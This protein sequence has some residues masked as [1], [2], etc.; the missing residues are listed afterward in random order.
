MSQ[1]RTKD[2]LPENDENKEF[3]SI[4]GII[5]MSILQEAAF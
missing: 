3:V 1:K 4:S 2:P 5:K